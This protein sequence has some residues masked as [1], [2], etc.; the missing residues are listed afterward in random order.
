MKAVIFTLTIMFVGLIVFTEFRDPPEHMLSRSDKVKN[1]LED[2]T[3]ST[4][5]YVSV[6]YQ[7]DVEDKQSR[8]ITKTL[9]LKTYDEYI[10]RSP[11]TKGTY[12]TAL[13][14]MKNHLPEYDFGEPVVDTA[15]YFSWLT[16]NAQWS[17]L[18]IETSNGFF[19][20]WKRV[21][22][23]HQFINENK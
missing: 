6:L 9:V 17:V 16:P 18:A 13:S 21:A 11:V 1:L 23:K 8:K 15:N 4:P 14:T 5:N 20:R 19:S 22:D 10:P 12:Q 7:T 3:L 2:V